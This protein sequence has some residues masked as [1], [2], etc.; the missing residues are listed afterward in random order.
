MFIQ[1]R[2]LTSSRGV[3]AYVDQ[4]GLTLLPP[5]GTPEQIVVFLHGIHGRGEDWMWLADVWRDF[6]P[7]AVFLFPNATFP[8]QVRP[9]GHVWWNI[10]FNEARLRRDVARVGPMLMELLDAQLDRYALNPGAM[11]LGGFSQGAILALHVGTHWNAPLAG[12]LCYSGVLASLPRSRFRGRPMPPVLLSYGTDDKII[13]AAMLGNT[14]RL[15]RKGRCDIFERAAIGS[16]HIVDRA[17]ASLG[18]ELM[19]NWFACPNPVRNRPK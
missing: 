13:P 8:S 6:L 18:G 1:T 5:E 2:K 3:R 16:G 7:R 15:L 4:G 12:I 10:S 19:R 9:E 11:I 14:G 17:G